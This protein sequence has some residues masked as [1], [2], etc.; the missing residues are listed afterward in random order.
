MRIA[1]TI[2]D[3]LIRGHL[4]SGP[5]S[6]HLREV[7]RRMTFGP[8][9]PPESDGNARRLDWRNG[10]PVNWLAPINVDLVGVRCHDEED[11]I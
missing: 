2:F 9:G 7:A 1:G 3:V 10:L 8:I 6:C 5:F 4:S 11:R